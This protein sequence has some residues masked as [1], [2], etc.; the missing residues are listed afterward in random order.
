M[1]DV[2][3]MESRTAHTHLEELWLLSVSSIFVA[4]LLWNT[5]KILQTLIESIYFQLEFRMRFSHVCDQKE[6]FKA[7]NASKMT[8]LE[9]IFSQ[10]WKHL[11]VF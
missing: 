1:E 7:I 8:E 5:S 11:E 6:I 9:L 4:D 2:F 10:S 3:S